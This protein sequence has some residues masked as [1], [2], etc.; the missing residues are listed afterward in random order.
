MIIGIG[1]AISDALS[2]GRCLVAAGSVIEVRVAGSQA[3]WSDP[4]MDKKGIFEYMF[5]LIE[6]ARDLKEVSLWELYLS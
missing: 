4:A 1:T 2:V 5:C 3:R 6:G